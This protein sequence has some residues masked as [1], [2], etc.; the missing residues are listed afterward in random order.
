MT[1]KDAGMTEKIGMKE[2]CEILRKSLD[3]LPLRNYI[4]S[5]QMFITWQFLLVCQRRLYE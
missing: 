3:I 2:I 1:R 5:E 4:Y